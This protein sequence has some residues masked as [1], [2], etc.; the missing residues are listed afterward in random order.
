MHS[1][2]LSWARKSSLFNPVQVKKFFDLFDDFAGY[3]HFFLSDDLVDENYNIK[4]YLPF[5]GFNTRPTFID[6]NQY[7]LYKNGV[8]NFIRSRNKRVENYIKK[9]QRQV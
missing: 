9:E 7:L 2:F 4:F 3:T 1:S 5:D 8:I 6:V